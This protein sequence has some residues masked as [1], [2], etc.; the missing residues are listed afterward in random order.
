MAEMCLRRTRAD[1]VVPVYRRLARIASTPA[2]LLRNAAEVRSVMRSLGLHWRGRNMVAMARA[3]VRRH[4]GRVPRTEAELKRLPGVG[5]YVA[6]AVLA[7]AMSR[8]AVLLDTN[9]R[10]IVSR[11]KR[12][13]KAHAWQVRLD[14]YELAG[15]QGPDAPLN[16]ALLDLG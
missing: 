3:V 5:E 1:Q 12:D 15:P 6:R 13:D 11:V 7:F 10:R 16:Y 2:A 9:T 8:P 14:L 4:N